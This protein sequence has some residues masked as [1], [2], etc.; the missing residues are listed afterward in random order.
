[1]V[2]LF[3]FYLFLYLLFF[4]SWQREILSYHFPM[5]QRP[6]KLIYSSNTIPQISPFSVGTFPSTLTIQDTESYHKDIIQRI[7]KFKTM[8]E[9][10]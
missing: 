1:M 6:S 10:V 2:F 3:P 4:F 7:S 9:I 5:L 8:G